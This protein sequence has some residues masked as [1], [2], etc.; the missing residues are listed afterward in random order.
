MASIPIEVSGSCRL[1][2]LSGTLIPTPV[3]EKPFEITDENIPI[4]CICIG[5]CQPFGWL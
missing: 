1:L 2:L 3:D 4:A 5:F